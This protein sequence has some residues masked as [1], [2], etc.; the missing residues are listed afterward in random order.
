MILIVHY[1]RNS[2]DDIVGKIERANRS[3]RPI[4]NKRIKGWITL[5]RWVLK[6]IHVI[7]FEYRIRRR[8]YIFRF[9]DVKVIR[10]YSVEYAIAKMGCALIADNSEKIVSV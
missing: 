6:Y 8:V 10:L 1:R 2:G 7:R 5:M 3:S 9:R 4:D